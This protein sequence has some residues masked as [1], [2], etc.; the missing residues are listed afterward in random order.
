MKTRSESL[1]ERNTQKMVEGA[2]SSTAQAAAPLKISV[3]QEVDLIP[4][5]RGNT[6]GS[7]CDDGTSVSLSQ[8]F[9]A[10]E[11]GF[12]TSKTPPEDRR[13]VA[14]KYVDKRNGDAC[15]LLAHLLD[16]K[17]QNE[18]WKDIKNR[19]SLIYPTHNEKNY[20]D[21]VRYTLFRDCNAERKH[22]ATDVDKLRRT[23]NELTKLYLEKSGPEV[24][25]GSEKVEV[26]QTVERVFTNIISC[27]L[28]SNYLNKE[29]A[30]KVGNQSKIDDVCKELL[31]IGNTC[32]SDQKIWSPV[33]ANVAA[34]NIKPTNNRNKKTNRN[35]QQNP[36][37]NNF[38]QNFP[39]NQVPQTNP[40]HMNNQPYQPQNTGSWNT[41]AATGRPAQGR[42]TRTCF[43]CKKIG[44]LKRD[45]RLRRA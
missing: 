20:F 43:N 32:P 25:N 39:V 21:G 7:D 42:E 24:I 9:K 2:G 38:P 16:T 11:S 45:C 28:F 10:L 44:H 30:R 23:V 18:S 41:P 12:L 34:V 4:L 37:L 1:K 19:I 29:V 8:W 26:R 13:I 36:P 14:Y 40:N 33:Q 17:Y 6:E 27:K 5:F 22:L 15:K 3:K 31:T 35:F